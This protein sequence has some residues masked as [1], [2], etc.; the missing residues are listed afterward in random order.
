[1]RTFIVSLGS[2]HANTCV[3]NFTRESSSPEISWASLKS[4][5][6]LSCLE[7]S[8]H[9]GVCRIWAFRF[10]WKCKHCISALGD[11][12][13]IYQQLLKHISRKNSRDWLFLQKTTKKI[14]QNCF[15]NVPTTHQ[16]LVFFFLT[17]FIK[18]LRRRQVNKNELSF[19]LFY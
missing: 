18:P 3:L 4:R 6:R 15:I 12:H 1:M 13:N 14:N 2:D 19:V 17:K 9:V 10:Y 11:M 16:V 8:M 7:L 5:G